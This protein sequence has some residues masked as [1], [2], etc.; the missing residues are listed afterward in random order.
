[1]TNISRMIIL[2]LVAFAAFAFP[3]TASAE[4]IYYLVGVRHVYRIGPDMY[5]HATERKQIEQDYADEVSADNAHYQYQIS[6][7]G[8]VDAESAQLSSALHD[9]AAERESRLSALYEQCDYVRNNHPSFNLTVDGP[10][11]VIGVRYHVYQSA[12]VWDDY[13][14]Y[15]PWPGYVVEG[16][17]PYGWRYGVV[18]TP[19]L[20]IS[21]YH[22]WYGGWVGFG[23]PAFVGFY[24]Y[25]GPIVCAGLSINLSF[26]FGAGH[27]YSNPGLG[28]YYHVG[29]G[30]FAHDVFRGG[31]IANRRDTRYAMA[32]QAGYAAG[33]AAIRSAR[34]AGYASGIRAGARSSFGSAMGRGAGGAVRSGYTHSS[35]VGRPRP[36]GGS[37]GRN[38]GGSRPTSGYTH[39]S[40]PARAP[41][42]SGSFGRG[43]APAH[44][45]GSFSHRSAPARSPSSFGRS[46]S[47]HAPTSSH[48][49]SSHSAPRS[50]GGGRSFGGGGRSFG[51]GSSHSGGGGHSSGKR[52]H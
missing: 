8:N 48:T 29:P 51:G 49:S 28:G 23:S 1:M 34:A 46:G 38:P 43:S 36:A 15:A 50:S 16:P 7:G 32:R 39:S 2:A 9:L 13:T 20:F 25:G 11:Q 17:P 31:Y 22:G 44:S 27:Y 14:A 3:A 30:Y 26:G 21:T 24:G 45:S 5:Y 52:G 35:S 12:E 33:A 47:F 18:Y 40:G 19:G 10:Y 41:A 37:F 42:R 6:H 4:R